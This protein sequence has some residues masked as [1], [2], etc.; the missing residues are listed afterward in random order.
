MTKEYRRKTNAAVNLESLKYIMVSEAI[1]AFCTHFSD[2]MDPTGG[3]VVWGQRYPAPEGES[4][5]ED[6]EHEEDSSSVP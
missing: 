6:E 1:C 3:E 4:E 5:T 2:I